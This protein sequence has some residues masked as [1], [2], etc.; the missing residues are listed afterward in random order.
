[1][2]G[3]VTGKQRFAIVTST[4]RPA[5]NM[6]CCSEWLEQVTGDPESGEGSLSASSQAMPRLKHLLVRAGT[7]FSHPSSL[8]LPS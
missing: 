5:P 3:R 4:L 1:M 7:S 2:C 6:P 8:A